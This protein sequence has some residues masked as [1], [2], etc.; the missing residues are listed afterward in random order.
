MPTNAVGKGA[1]LESLPLTEIN[2]LE[3]TGLWCSKCSW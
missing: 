1:A 2:V 3:Q